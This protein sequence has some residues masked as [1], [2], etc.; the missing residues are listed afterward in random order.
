MAI[1][2]IGDLHL[3][4]GSE[5]PMDVFAGWGN[6]AGR[7]RQ[8][9]Q[10]IVSAEDTVVV[11]GDISWAMN[12]NEAYEDF[13]F[14]H[15]L[16]GSKIIMKGNHDYWWSTMA[17]MNAWLQGNG[18]S[19]IQFLFN[20]SFVVEGIG[21][22]GTRSWFYEEGTSESDPVYQRELGRLKASIASLDGTD[23]TEKIA[24]L[25]YPPIYREVVVQDVLDI[26]KENGI[27]RC[28]YGHLHGKSIDYAFNGEHDGIRFQL[29]SA[30]YLRF[31]PYKIL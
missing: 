29:I 27:R 23:V 3:S 20:N 25:H 22:C 24:F 8:N 14:I 6:H 2:A 19:S 7:L 15:G 30:D 11:A 9:W 13:S 17:K 21:I 26:L 12:F 5:K 18:F 16:P 28:Y 4:F 31:A 10:N 1:Y